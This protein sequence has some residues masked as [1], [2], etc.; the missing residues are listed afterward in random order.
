MDFSGC[1]R[2][3]HRTLGSGRRGPLLGLCT[4]T[5]ASQVDLVSD[6]VAGP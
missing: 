2:R 5:A 1:G 6:K 4:A 3:L